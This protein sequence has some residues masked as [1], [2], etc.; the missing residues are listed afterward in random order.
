MRQIAVKIA[1]KYFAERC[2][3]GIRN[4]KFWPTIKPF[5]SSKVNSQNNMILCEKKIND[6]V[7]KRL[8]YF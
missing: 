2:D 1:A 8:H 6:M 5:L 4:Q 3:G 7:W